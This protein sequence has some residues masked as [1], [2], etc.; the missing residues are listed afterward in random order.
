MPPSWTITL[1]LAA[2]WLASGPATADLAAQAHRV[3]MFAADGFAIWDNSWYG[4]HPLP[5]YSLIFPALGSAFGARL[6]GAF[7]AVGSAA[8]FERLLPDHHRHRPATWWFA[9]GCVADLMIGRL[10][11]ALGL[12]AGLAAAVAI[13]RR[14]PVLAAALGAICAATSPVAGL[15]VA[16]AGVA[17]AIVGRRRDPLATSAAA[18]A[19]VVVL[20]R[21]FPEG[22]TQPFSAGSF[23]VTAGVTLAAAL[24]VGDRR[25]RVPLLLY[26]SAAVVS[27]LV[28]SPMG[29][30]VVRLG[31]TFVAPAL[32]LAARRASRSRRVVLVAILV[33]AAAW[34]WIDPFTQAAHGWGDR[35]AR[36]TYYRPLIRAVA[37][38]GGPAGRVEVP[39]TRNHW[40]TVFLAR[41]FALARGWE[42]QLD[43]RLNPLFYD[44]SLTPD[45]YHRWLRGNAVRY[46]ALADVP[47]DGAGRSEA[48]L[49][50]SHP[51]FLVSVWRGPHWQ[52]FRVR[53]AVPLA[54]GAVG[55]VQLDQTGLRLTATRAGPIVARVRWSPYWTVVAGEGCVARRGRWTLVRAWRPGSLVL[56]VR[57]SVG[58]LLD[59]PPPCSSAPPS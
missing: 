37:A 43:R 19:V 16:L 21:A 33:V 18:G 39:F 46:V 2:C 5:G 41:R 50:R 31:T 25:L 58:R 36:A 59:E 10:T 14:R 47:I 55:S 44:K 30:N 15:F 38:Q 27:F 56:T 4:G 8:L 3:G 57:F 29:G 11:Y 28:A 40:E 23:A 9:V 26:A 42:R 12:T 34:Q 52:L 6:V 7:A 35:S 20:S 49:V 1:V 24:A 13:T 17:F 53:D 32:L 22:G 54:T 51:P 45:A 48:A